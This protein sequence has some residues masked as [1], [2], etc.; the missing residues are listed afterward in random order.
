M[1]KKQTDS[2]QNRFTAYLMAAVANK[3]I[4]YF[5]QRNRYKE[6][7]YIQV[8]LLEK[9]HVDFEAQYRTY[10]AE[11]SILAY[12]GCG[13]SLECMPEIDS[14]QLTK[15][16]S[17]LKDRER[18]I[19]FARVF[20]ELNFVELGERFGMEAKQAEMAYY[21]IIRKLRKG[22]GDRKDEF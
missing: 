2:V 9:N 11:Q 17:R 6:R 13:E 15:C 12:F 7:E 10:L 21:Y 5:E 18:R 3:R 22:M 16:I 1:E 20:G 8:D 19:L 14:I 4:S